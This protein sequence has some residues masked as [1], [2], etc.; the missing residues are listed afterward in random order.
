MEEIDLDIDNYDLN[1]L[2]G[3]FKL[4]M[5]YGDRELSHAK[6]IVLKL[7]PDKSRMDRK[8]FLF[9]MKAY[10]ILLQLWKFRN[11]SSPSSVSRNINNG[12]EN[13]VYISDTGTDDTEEKRGLLKK[14]FSDNKE[15]Q[16]APGFNK[17]FNNEFEKA[18]LDSED[19]AGYGDWLRSQED[20]NSDTG[21][22]S[23][24]QMKE[25]FMKKKQ[26]VC[27]DVVVHQEVESFYSGI[28]NNIGSSL[29]GG[30]ENGMLYDSTG[31]SGIAYQDLQKAHTETIIPVSEEDYNRRKKFSSL[32]QMRVYRNGQD[33]APLNVEE[34][35]R[36][37][38]NNT[39]QEDENAIRR[40]YKLAKQSEEAN[41]KSGEFWKNLR[42]LK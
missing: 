34:S 18:K 36:M 3:L 31:G 22:M 35:N 15:L 2:L 21:K 42:L 32:D 33:T 9:Y 7:H 26:Q 25:E 23:M 39:K 5:N 11:N 27:R 8:Y 13:M 40:A 1:D 24:G 30:L 29:G 28:G 20:L 14:M 10:K 19:N 41:K 6:K 16:S 17:W 12:R 37:L 4:D 38:A